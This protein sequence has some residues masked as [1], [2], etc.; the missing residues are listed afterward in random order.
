MSCF[1][2]PVGI[3][4][5]ERCLP[6]VHVLAVAATLP[7]CANRK[8]KYIQRFLES[9]ARSLDWFPWSCCQVAAFFVI[10]LTRAYSGLVLGDFQ[11]EPAWDRTPK[12]LFLSG[13]HTCPTWVLPLQIYLIGTC[14]LTGGSLCPKQI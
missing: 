4:E 1:E 2:P 11:K 3:A 12:E 9:N 7:V 14:A 6:Y 13:G 5:L 10:A 8:E